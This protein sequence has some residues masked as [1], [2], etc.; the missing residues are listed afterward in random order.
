MSTALVTGATAGIGLAFAHQLAERGHDLVLV[1]RDRARLENVSDEL[2]AKY[3]VGAEVLVADLSDRADTG[4]VA[5]RLADQAR[6]VDLLVNNAGYGAQAALPRQRHHRGGGRASTCSAGPCSCC[7][8]PP[9]GPCASGGTVPSS[10]S[11]RWPASVA[12]GTY[13]AAK[14][15]VTVFTEGLAS[16]LAGTGVTATALL[17]GL[18]PH[19]VPPARPARHVQ[20][21]AV[22]VAR[23]RPPGQRLPRRRRPGARSSPCRA[24]QYKAIVGPAARAA[25]LTGAQPGPHRPPPEG[26]SPGRRG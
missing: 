24:P 5:E 9:R 17:P 21:A 10:T 6:P 20:P 11:R 4:K 19:R 1:A 7:R 26:L 16:E 18:H 12:S 15:F 14:A 3:D 13:S 8:T 22:H 25:A 2:R 23:P